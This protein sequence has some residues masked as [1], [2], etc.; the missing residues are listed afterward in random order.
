MPKIKIQ[1]KSEGNNLAS[2]SKYI[3]IYL[4]S[5]TYVEFLSLFFW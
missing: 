1:D 2:V 5:V 4:P 3:I